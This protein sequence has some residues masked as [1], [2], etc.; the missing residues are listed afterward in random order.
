MPRSNLISLFA[1]FERYA[2]DVAVVQRHGYRSECWTY[3]QL[4]SA[5]SSFSDLLQKLGV[6]ARERVILWGPNSAEWMASFWGCLLRGAVA[7]PLD[8]GAPAGFAARG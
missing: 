6:R 7:V 1:E 2:K 4:A 5:A 3:A 8:D